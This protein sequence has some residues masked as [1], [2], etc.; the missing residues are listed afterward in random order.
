M[1][2]NKAEIEVVRLNAADIL[3]TSPI[4]CPDD[5]SCDSPVPTAI[6]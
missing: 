1:K 5:C 4:V 2:F 6:M 3:T